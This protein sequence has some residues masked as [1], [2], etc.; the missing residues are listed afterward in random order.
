[1]PLD[2]TLRVVAFAGSVRRRSINQQLL[3]VAST[4]VE[5]NGAEVDRLSL[6]DF[7]MPMYN[8]DLQAERGVPR[9]TAALVERIHAS[10]ALLIAS[11]EYNGGY[12]PLLKNTIDWT[13]RIDRRLFFPR[14]MGLMSASPGSR[15]GVR[16]LSQLE[17]LFINMRSTVLQPSFS[18]GNFSER[19]HDGTI[20]E[21]ELADSLQAWVK[22][23]VAAGIVLAANPPEPPG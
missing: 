3:D 1:M 23:F 12:T 16:G 7:P 20:F 14:L 17:Q 9:S 10:D 2:R 5:A 19:V 11:P 22:E 8:A 18:V 21:L 13:T 15:G 6:D 4:A